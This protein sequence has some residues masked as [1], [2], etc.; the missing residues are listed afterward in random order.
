MIK[1][2]LCVCIFCACWQNFH[3]AFAQSQTFYVWPDS[4]PGNQ[5]TTSDGCFRP[6]IEAYIPEPSKAT[7]AAFIICPGG[8]YFMLWGDEAAPPAQWLKSNGI[9]G[10]VLNYRHKD[11]KHPV[12]LWDARRAMR[13]VR[14]RADEFNIDPDR[15]GIMGFS[16]GGHL[17]STVGT[18]YDNG[19]PSS[20]DPVEHFSCKP[21]VM[22]LGYP[23]I[24]MNDPYAHGTTRGYLLGNNNSQDTLDYLS[25][26]KHVDENTPPTFITYGDS[27]DVVHPMNSIMFYDSLQKYG[28]TSKMVVEEGLKHGYYTEPSWTDTCLA[29]LEQTGFLSSTQSVPHRKG[30]RVSPADKEN[31][32]STLSPNI[33]GYSLPWA[34]S[35]LV[36]ATGARSAPPPPGALFDC[37]GRLLIHRIQY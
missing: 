31:A 28:V 14:S 10:F 4:L 34:Q 20:S 36:P 23:C 24:T 21:A 1:K 2:L 6:T 16:A 3:C 27:D 13:L 17:A 15:I 26:E 25:N 35:I 32:F 7:A 12:P 5:D 11:C 18:H 22:V 8:A 9:A 37:R 33:N 19:N 29:W 30:L